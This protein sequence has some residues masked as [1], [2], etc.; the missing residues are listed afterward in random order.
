[1]A[2]RLPIVVSGRS[3]DGAKPSL[4]ALSTIP[5]RV[6]DGLLVAGCP[7]YLECELE[8][9]VDGFGPNSLVV[10]RVVAASATHDA[11]R[12]F[13]TD[14]ADLIHRLG[15]LAYLAPGRFAVVRESRSF[16]YTVDFRL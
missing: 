12:A 4:A 1:M 8:R 7:L 6:V 11:L 5:A 10:G 15:L 14:D 3:E 9:V 2:L 13:E 16:P